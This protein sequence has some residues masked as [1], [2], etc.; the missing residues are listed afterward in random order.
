M[1][2]IKDFVRPIKPK[3]PIEEINEK[4]GFNGK[5]KTIK[6]YDN[7]GREK[8]EESIKIHVLPDPKEALL[9]TC[10][11]C[12][13]K[14]KIKGMSG[15]IRLKHNISGISLQDLNDVKK[16]LKSLEELVC[17][18]FNDEEEMIIDNL[19]D[20]I[21]EREFVSWKDV[22]QEKTDQKEITKQKSSQEEIGQEKTKL[23]L[24]KKTPLKDKK[25]QEDDKVKSKDG[26]GF[27]LA[28]FGLLA[29][30]AL[31]VMDRLQ[32]DR[33]GSEK[34]WLDPIYKFIGKYFTK[35]G[36]G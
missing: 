35:E 4:S 2:E 17:E 28:G 13:K 10:P 21:S 20:K 34:S 22:K 14:I 32:K 25:I 33:E 30:L 24:D 5:T 12:E 8:I 11:F 36:A 23:N 16:G 6:L 19:S 29:T 27:S 9:K 26:D 1:K 7:R 18:K 15:H 31:I 3:R